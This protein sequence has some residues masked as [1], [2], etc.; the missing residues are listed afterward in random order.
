MDYRKNSIPLNWRR[1][2]YL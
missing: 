1:L 2:L